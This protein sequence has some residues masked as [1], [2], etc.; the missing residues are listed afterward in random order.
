[1]HSDKCEWV[2]VSA[3]WSGIAQKLKFYKQWAFNYFNWNYIIG[4]LY[5]LKYVGESQALC[6]GKQV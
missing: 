4:K 2:H 1:M 3:S 5:M 6:V